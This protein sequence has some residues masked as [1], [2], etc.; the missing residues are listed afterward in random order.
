MGCNAFEVVVKNIKEYSEE[1]KDKLCSITA[2]LNKQTY[3]SMID[4]AKFVMK[5]FNVYNLYFSNYKGNNSE[6]AFSDYEID[7]MFDNYIPKT[8]DVFKNYGHDYSIKQ[9][10]LYS[11]ND[12]KNTNIRFPIN[13]TLP[14][15]IQLSEMTIDIYGKC[16]NCSHL[17]RDNVK[18]YVNIN[19][20]DLNLWAAFGLLKDQL[21]ENYICLSDKCLSGCNC[22]LIGFN[23]TVHE[24][25]YNGKRN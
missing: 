13:K 11:K 1:M 12:F 7:D 14:C 4:L 17:F 10:N 2:V 24:K 25:V 18:P 21:H 20:N 22:N 15:Y 3:K 6:F 16:Y 19:V 23:K 9:L 5:E 8:N